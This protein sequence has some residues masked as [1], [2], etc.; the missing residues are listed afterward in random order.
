MNRTVV[1]DPRGSYQFPTQHVLLVDDTTFGLE[2]V[3]A[4]N[5]RKETERERE[6]MPLS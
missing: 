6:T 2:L 5:T 3:F 1:G 4:W